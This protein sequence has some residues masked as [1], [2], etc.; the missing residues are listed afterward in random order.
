MSSLPPY[1][2]KISRN[3]DTSADGS[4]LLRSDVL[5]AYVSVYVNDRD[6]IHLY[7]LPDSY[8]TSGW[9]LLH[10]H[11]NRWMRN[12]GDD[13]EEAE[14]IVTEFVETY[15]DSHDDLDG[16][17]EAKRT[18]TALADA[19]G[20]V[21]PTTFRSGDGRAS[22]FEGAVHGATVRGNG[23]TECPEWAN[24]FPMHGPDTHY[25]LKSEIKD[26]RFHAGWNGTWGRMISWYCPKCQPE[27]LED[28][29]RLNIPYSETWW[30]EIDEL[31]DYTGEQPPL[32]YLTM[33]WSWD[34]RYA[35]KD[36]KIVVP[37]API[38]SETVTRYGQDSEETGSTEE[39]YQTSAETSWSIDHDALA[40]RLQDGPKSWLGYL[41]GFDEDILLGCDFVEIEV[42]LESGGKA[43]ELVIQDVEVLDRE[44]RSY[45]WE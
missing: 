32:Y 20:Q 21:V 3:E 41:N 18:N 28:I 34:D 7:V 12:V 45:P 15:D 33:L 37:D 42:E 31:A 43:A 19:F 13:A 1:W 9:L 40:K 11:Q 2:T 14:E 16:A 35:P 10:T 38:E 39:R 36:N 30:D 24:V 4:S 26:T 27:S 29:N 25:V 6:G 8:D 23:V 17:S 5:E 44:T 22:F